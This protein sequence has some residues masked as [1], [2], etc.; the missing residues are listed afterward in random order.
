V[1]FPLLNGA[2]TSHAAGG[3]SGARAISTYREG[4]P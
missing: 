3:V 1:G 4:Y 2:T